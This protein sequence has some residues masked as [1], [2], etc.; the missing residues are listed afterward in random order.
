[1]RL[2]PHLRTPRKDVEEFTSVQMSGIKRHDLVKAWVASDLRR[3]AHWPGLVLGTGSVVVVCGVLMSIFC[4]SISLNFARINHEHPRKSTTAFE[5]GAQADANLSLSPRAR[6]DLLARALRLRHSPLLAHRTRSSDA[7]SLP[8]SGC[9]NTSA[10]C[11]RRSVNWSAS[12]QN[13]NS[14]R[15]RLWRISR[16]TLNLA[17]W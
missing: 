10:H 17:T 3:C 15:R 7:R 5:H 8:P 2:R 6:Y 14:R 9:G 16:R 11:K 12:A 1:M 13:S 4:F